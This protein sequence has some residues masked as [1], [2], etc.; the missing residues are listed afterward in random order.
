MNKTF[1]TTWFAILLG[2]V[3]GWSYADAEQDFADG[4]EAYGEGKFAEASKWFAAAAE[5]GQ[6]EAQMKLGAMYFQGQGV[7]KNY[8]EALF[9]FTKAAER[10]N[11]EAQTNVG[12]L[13]DKAFGVEQDYKKAAYWYRKAAEQGYANAQFDLGMMYYEGLGVIQDYVEAHKWLNLAASN[14]HPDGA[15]SREHTEKLMT[16]AQIAEAQRRASE[17]QAGFEKR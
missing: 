11:L 5:Q 13:Y 3:S 10:G 4:L 14:D 6:I 7:E 1:L 8:G 17:W 9:W 16:N 2:L 12:Y 15:A